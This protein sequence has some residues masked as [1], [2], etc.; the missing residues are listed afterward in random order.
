MT[1]AIG[2]YYLGTED[3]G[4]SKFGTHKKFMVLNKCVNIIS[5]VICHMASFFWRKIL[6]NWQTGNEPGK[7]RNQVVT[8]FSFILNISNTQSQSLLKD[9]AK[10]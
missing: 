10:Y 5:H 9:F 1:M 2:G 4:E 7:E 8:F 3:G 6:N